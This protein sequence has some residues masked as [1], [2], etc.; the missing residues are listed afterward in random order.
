MQP[1]DDTSYQILES[2]KPPQSEET[3]ATASMR[4]ASDS[5]PAVDTDSDI[6]HSAPSAGVCRETHTSTLIRT[7]VFREYMCTVVVDK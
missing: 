5:L 6:Y 7:H 3:T 4:S 2:L 1:Q